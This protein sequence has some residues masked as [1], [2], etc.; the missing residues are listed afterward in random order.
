M[1]C[2]EDLLSLGAAVANEG[3]GIDTSLELRRGPASTV[4]LATRHSI[5][6]AEDGK[7]P[8]WRFFPPYLHGHGYE[9]SGATGGPVPGHEVLAPAPAD[10]VHPDST[11]SYVTYLESDDSLQQDAS[12]P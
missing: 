9:M 5:C 7:G 12:S 1:R 11:D 4:T 3:A 8:V 10:M 2:A 6:S